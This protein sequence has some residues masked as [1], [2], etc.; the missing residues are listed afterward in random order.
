[1]SR[2]KPPV[3]VSEEVK[4]AIEEGGS[5]IVECLESVGKKGTAPVGQW[6]IY[7]VSKDRKSRRMLIFKMS[8]EQEVIRTVT[9]LS[10]RLRSWG[11]PTSAVPN[12]K[13]QIVEIFKDGR[14]LPVDWR[15]IT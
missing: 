12:L 10:E 13:G 15:P 11:L 2:A 9:G 8:L 3:I 4:G 1:M 6:G 14:C 5:V 7:I